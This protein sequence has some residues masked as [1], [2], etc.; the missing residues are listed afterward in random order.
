MSVVTVLRLI[1][2]VRRG[3][4]DAAGL[5]FRRAVDLVVGFRFCT[6]SLSQRHRDCSG[7]R[8]LA[9]VNMANRANVN[10]RLVALK[11]FLRHRITPFLYFFLTLRGW[12]QAYFA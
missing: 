4:G 2:N 5:F 6:A 10:V 1:L 3:D 7:Q 11:F 9:V 8:R 12:D